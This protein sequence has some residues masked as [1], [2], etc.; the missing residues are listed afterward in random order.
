MDTEKQHGTAECTKPG[1]KDP[2]CHLI[3]GTLGRSINFCEAQFFLK[4]MTLNQ[5]RVM[6]L[7]FR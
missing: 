2:D 6:A 1:L 7:K 4:T 5:F 3:L